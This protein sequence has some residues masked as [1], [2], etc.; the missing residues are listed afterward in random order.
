MTEFDQKIPVHV[1]TTLYQP[2]SIDD[3]LRTQLH[4]TNLGTSVTAGSRIHAA[5]G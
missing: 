2:A 4:F 3:L 5:R 1:R